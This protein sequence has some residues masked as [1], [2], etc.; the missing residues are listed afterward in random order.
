MKTFSKSK[1]ALSVILSAVI[2]LLAMTPMVALA[3]EKNYI[4]TNPYEEIDWDTWGDYKTQLHCHTNASDGFLPIDEFVRIHY[5]ADFDIVALTDHGTINQGWNNEPELVPLM[6][7]IKKDRTNMSDVIPIPQDEYEAYLDGTNDN[8][9][10]VTKD[11]YTLTRTHENGM[12]DI[13]KGI[14]LNMATP[15][16]DCHL[17]GYFSDYGQGLAGVFGDYE[18]PSKGVMDEG[19]ISYLS[20]VGE[21]VYTDKDSQNY[22]GQPVNDYYANKFARLFIDYQG[23]SLGMGINSATDAHTRCDRIL[24]GV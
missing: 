1:K 2:V 5:A 14:E 24:Y 3:D 20:H 11:G 9:T 6:R 12:L 23:S 7:F 22:V 16:A 10:Y 8:I 4:I 13:P 18:T 15:I 19:G 21:Y 17:T